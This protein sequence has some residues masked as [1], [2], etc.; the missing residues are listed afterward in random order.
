LY[1]N[2]ELIQGAAKAA[3]AFRGIDGRA[4]IHKILMDGMKPARLEKSHACRMPSPK[5]F[6]FD[7]CSS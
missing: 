3:S 2:N 5:V 1:R 7:E 6:L 4:P